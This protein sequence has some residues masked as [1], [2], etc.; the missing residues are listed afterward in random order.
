MWN[1]IGRQ[2]EVNF[3]KKKEGMGQRGHVVGHFGK[4]C[5]SN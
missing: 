4:N 1:G 2:A 5:E 3:G